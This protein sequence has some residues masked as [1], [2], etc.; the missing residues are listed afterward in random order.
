MPEAIQVAVSDYRRDEDKLADFIED[1]IVEVHGGNIRHPDLY[2]IYKQHCERGGNHPWSSRALIGALR[3]RDWTS[4]KLWDCKVVWT[5][6]ALKA[7]E[8]NGGEPF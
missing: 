6:Y 4:V 1:E 5:G 3:D 8:A 2:N 7:H